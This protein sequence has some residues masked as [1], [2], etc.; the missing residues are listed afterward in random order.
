MNRCRLR[1]VAPVQVKRH[2]LG[3]T[4]AVQRI[5][6]DVGGPSSMY[7]LEDELCV[8]QEDEPPRARRCYAPAARRWSGARPIV[9]PASDGSALKVVASPGR[10]YRFCEQRNANVI[11]PKHVK[12]GDGSR[13]R[14]ARAHTS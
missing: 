5:P 4:L 8:I 14:P 3:S 12:P 11:V 13:A 2:R 1:V 6:L 7:W 10:A 9:R